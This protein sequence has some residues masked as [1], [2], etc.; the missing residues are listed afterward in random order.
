[1]SFIRLLCSFIVLGFTREVLGQDPLFTQYF[2]ALPVINPAF[3]GVGEGLRWHNQVR[4]N[5]VNWPTPFKTAQVGLEYFI[6]QVSSGVGL[7]MLTDDAGNGVVKTSQLSGQFAYQLQIN[8]KWFIR[9]GMEAGFNQVRLNWSELYFEDQLDPYR[10]LEPSL[11]V[12]EIPPRTLSRR[13]WDI[14]TGLLVFSKSVY[15]GISLRHLN[16]Y[17][18]SFWTGRKILETGRPMVL[19]LHAGWDVPLQGRGIGKGPVFL[20]P[21]ALW[22]SSNQSRILQFGSSW[23]L[24]QFITGA[25]TRLG[26]FRPIE[27]MLG[28]G[29][30]YG[31]YRIMYTAEVPLDSKG[32]IR[33]FGSHEL[34]FS[35]RFSE[36]PGYQSRRSAQKTLN[37]FRFN[38]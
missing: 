37:C 24:G 10:G 17:R 20:S 26:S 36:A 4:M 1:M 12:T 3:A 14:G 23:H 35:L 2:S 11:S 28:L 29:F 27:G 34:A 38:D 25:W 31:I 5:W 15:A 16:R 21:M 30:K 9:L 33:T 13:E 22:L 32:I 18:Q 19:S 7:R 6:P 8:R